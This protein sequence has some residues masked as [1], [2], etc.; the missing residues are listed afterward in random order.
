MSELAVTNR[1]RLRR[2]AFRGSHER[3]VIDAILDEA[4]VCHVGFATEN[5]PVV[6]P[7]SFVRVG[8]RVYL[9]GSS[10]NH[11][12][13]MAARGSD[14]SIAVTLLDGLVLARTAFHHS[15]NYRSV[16]MFGVGLTITDPSEK[17]AVLAALVDR[18][19]PSRSLACRAPNDDELKGTLVIAIAIDEASA[20]V[21]SGPPLADEGGDASLPFWAGEV[22][23][24]SVRGVPVNAPDCALPA[25]IE[26]PSG[27]PEQACSAR[28]VEAALEVNP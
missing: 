14:V 18:M 11:M 1:T 7:T 4:L 16:V 10:S 28:V 8:D 25:P 3:R 9:H 5:G 17:R 27:C 20:K 26:L 19:T 13:R 12:L 23:I 2:R 22:P 6:I 24:R 21:R 15:M